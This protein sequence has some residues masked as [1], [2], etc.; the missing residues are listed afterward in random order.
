ME[1]EIKYGNI[2]L[3]VINQE[4]VSVWKNV[5]YLE[6]LTQLQLGGLAQKHKRCPSGR[7]ICPYCPATFWNMGNSKKTPQKN[8]WPNV[9]IREGEAMNVM[10][11][12]SY[13]IK[14]NKIAQTKME[15]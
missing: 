8:N 6:I 12:K 2:E 13:K 9:G 11:T 4:Y 15:N 7:V 1:Q 10:Q 14:Q 5:T 3:N